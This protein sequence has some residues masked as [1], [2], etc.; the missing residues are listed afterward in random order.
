MNTKIVPCLAVA[1]A[2]VLAVPL[3]CAAQTTPVAVA[4]PGAATPANAPIEAALQRT[5]SE[6]K[7]EAVPLE[8][9]LQNLRETMGVNMHV[10]WRRLEEANVPRDLPITMRLSNL[11][12]ER[13]LRLV[14]DE[15]EAR[16]AYS[17][18]DGVLI[19]STFD[20]LTRRRTAE[21][22]DLRELLD[23]LQ[24]EPRAAHSLSGAAASVSASDE[25]R[26]I[27]DLR[28]AQE[29]EEL[30]PTCVEPDAWMMNGGCGM[31]R[32]VGCTLVVYQSSHVHRELRTL[33]EEL[34]RTASLRQPAK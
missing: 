32:R 1:V 21:V 8:Q 2:F 7:F 16:L 26:R 10:R 27:A 14:L 15:A 25:A 4:A 13:V 30:I 31:V 20:D 18:E 24:G 9:V 11:P 5:M 34:R 17:V 3:P 6:V 23:A 28:L 29:I 12:T 22:Y 33:L 19:V